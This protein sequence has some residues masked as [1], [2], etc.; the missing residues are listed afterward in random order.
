MK[1][2]LSASLKAV[3]T[4]NEHRAHVEALVQKLKDL[5]HQVE[6]KHVLDIKYD[7]KGGMNDDSRVD[8]YQQIIKGINNADMV[9]ADLLGANISIGHQITIALEKNKPVLAVNN[10]KMPE[11]LH[12]LEEANQLYLVEYSTTEDL[13]GKLEDEIRQVKEGEDIRF[14]FLIPPSMVDYL[15]WVS[16][17][18]RIPKSVFIRDLI[19]GEMEADKEYRSR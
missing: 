4:N 18:R 2:F 9:V 14:N 11:I 15:E 8:Y 5:G 1:I 19:K 7:S 17:F 16:K 12:A 10:G 3:T 6:S 13:L